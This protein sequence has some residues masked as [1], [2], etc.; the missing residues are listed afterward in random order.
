MQK[1]T[2]TF[3]L[4]NGYKIPCIGY[5][6]WQMPDGE[7]A[8]SAVKCALENG[9]RHIDTA[10]IYKNEK[11]AGQ[12][13]RESG[14]PREEIFVTSKVWNAARGYET[15]LQ[16]FD[17]TMDKLGLDYLDLYL[18][19]WP[20]SSSTFPD[21]EQ[22]NLQT[23]KALT[24]L[25]KV[26]RIKS[27]GVSNFLVHHLNALMQTEIQPMVNQIEFHPGQMQT[28]TYNYCKQ[29]GILIEAWGPLGSGKML[30]DPTLTQIAAKYNKS[31]AQLCIRWCLQNGTLP[32][33]KS[34]T[35][36]RIAANTQVLDFEITQDD[37]NT[38]NAMPYFGGSGFHPD[39][40]KF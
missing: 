11:S 34:A 40:V 23:W 25:Y 16:A 1:L 12:A 18:I 38:I 14:I 26:G 31:T 35:P 5:G 21:W 29:H 27:I 15:T 4:S 39:E 19:H 3:T 24:E 9:Y 36:A 17:K 8:T 13:I 22:I 30:E 33:P 20:A 37:M 2:D 7:E 32:L 28:E 6:T 10:A